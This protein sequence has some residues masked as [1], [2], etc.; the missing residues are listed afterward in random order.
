M[1]LCLEAFVG[2]IGFLIPEKD[3]KDVK[4][5]KGK[6]KENLK[7]IPDAVPEVEVTKPEMEITVE[8]N[9]NEVEKCEEICK[10]SEK[11]ERVSSLWMEYD[12]F[13][14]CFR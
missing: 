5:I 13:C 7:D 11:K 6:S 2:I 10:E 12:D 14:L 3:G 1:I 8:N 9:E 4:E